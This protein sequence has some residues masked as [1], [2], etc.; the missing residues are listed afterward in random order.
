MK[1]L[2]LVSYTC[3]EQFD[4]HSFRV[5]DYELYRSYAK[6]SQRCADLDMIG[7]DTIN[8]REISMIKHVMLQIVA[9]IV[10]YFGY[11]SERGYHLFWELMSESGY[12][13]HSKLAAWFDEKVYKYRKAKGLPIGYTTVIE[14][15]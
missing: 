2:Y 15:R 5:T 8:V 12:D 7:A 11:R 14:G 9:A 4:G 3:T 6:M 10:G 13:M 1:K